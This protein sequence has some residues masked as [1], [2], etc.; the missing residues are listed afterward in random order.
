MDKIFLRNSSLIDEE[1]QII[2]NRN[3]LITQGILEKISSSEIEEAEGMQ[4]IE[5]SNLF[6]IP[7][8]V[9]LHTYYDWW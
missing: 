6:I 8:L 7:G 5:C 1:A 9:N 2:Q 4:V 3:I